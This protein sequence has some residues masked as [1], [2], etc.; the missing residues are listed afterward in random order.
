MLNLKIMMMILAVGGSYVHS[1]ESS[2]SIHVQSEEN[3]V[4]EDLVPENVKKLFNEIISVRVGLYNDVIHDIVLWNQLSHKTGTADHVL[5]TYIITKDRKKYFFK[6]GNQLENVDK[7]IELFT[8]L[9][10][11]SAAIKKILEKNNVFL[12]IPTHYGTL[13][14]NTTPWLRKPT[15]SQG[16]IV[17]PIIKPIYYTIAECASG[18][19]F[20]KFLRTDKKNPTLHPIDYNEIKKLS[21][22]VG[23]ALAELHNVGLVHNDAHGNN[24]FIDKDTM[25]VYFIDLI[26]LKKKPAGEYELMSCLIHLLEANK[27]YYVSRKMK[28]YIGNLE[29][30]EQLSD[31]NY[32]EYVASP[33]I[34]AYFEVL[35]LNKFEKPDIN[36]AKSSTLTGNPQTAKGAK[37][38]LKAM[39]IYPEKKGY[40]KNKRNELVTMI[41][42]KLNEVDALKK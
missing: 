16:M 30:F 22:T 27:Y 21:Q 12:Q 35:N 4:Q 24:I 19:E 9:N 37:R 31:E 39:K 6:I 36:S 26:T 40:N 28:A 29:E 25:R 1:V 13:Q 18:Q 38:T 23:R 3:V 41:T 32:K 2:P 34:D 7:V 14:D 33:M 10:T 15:A 8:S 42:N 5:S 20:Y 17:E 11:E